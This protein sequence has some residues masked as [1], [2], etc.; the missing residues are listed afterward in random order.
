LTKKEKKR[1]NGTSEKE[2]TTKPEA[3]RPLFAL[4]LAT[5]L[6]VGYLP[7]APGTWGSAA[8]IALVSGTAALTRSESG[9][10]IVVSEF[11]LLLALAGIGLW[12]SQ[13]VVSA[14]PSDPDPGNVVIDE[15]SGQTI[16]LVMGLALSAWT[17]TPSQ[18]TIIA[19]VALA[20]SRGLLNWKYLVAGF[21][22]FRVFDIWKPFPARR[23]ESLPGGLGI[24]ADD[25][26]AGAYAAFGLWLIR[27]L[28]F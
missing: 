24:M 26:V 27:A 28:R 8:A 19:K 4:A 2:M 14:D 20:L 10:L 23:A 25:W 18:E 16:S 15:L 21:I 12:A 9:P 5:S 13:R 1:L 6:G 11:S 17:A 3:A 22:L 7:L